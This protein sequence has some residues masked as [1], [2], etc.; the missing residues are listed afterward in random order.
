MK[1]LALVLLLAPLF[2]EFRSA[3]EGGATQNAWSK[4]ADAF[5]AALTG[6]NEEKL[7]KAADPVVKDNSERAAKLLL[8]GLSTKNPRFYWLLIANL[9]RLGSKESIEP[10]TAAILAS[11]GDAALKRDLMMALQ[12]NRS[13]WADDA[14]LHIAAKGT[15]DVAVTAFDE[16][17]ARGKKE[18][19]QVLIDALKKSDEELKRRARKALAALTGAGHATA[20]EWQAWWDANAGTWTAP[21]T[22]PKAD[23]DN[24]GKTVAETLKRNRMTDYEE[25]T[26]L[27]AKD[28]VVVEGT[29]DRV[30]DVLGHMKIPHTK[31]QPKDLARHDL[32]KTMALLINCGVC[33]LPD[34]PMDQFELTLPKAVLEKIRAFVARGGYLFA[35]DWGLTEVLEK[36]FPGTVKKSADI[37]E[38]VVDIYPK[39]GSTGHPFLRE[40]FVKTTTSGGEDGKSATSTQERIDFKWVIDG[41]TFTID[42]DPAKVVCLI[43]APDLA[44]AKN[45]AVAVT[46]TWGDD[47]EAGKAVATGGVFENLS[48]IKSGK[49]LHVL[50]H[51]GNQKTKDDTYSVQ[52]MLL[53]F[54]IEAKDRKKPLKKR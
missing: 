7:Q 42:Y 36:A 29:F 18:A 6:S 35:S 2:D 23:P 40:V 3:Q 43:E 50:S 25:L 48:A 32:S 9:A 1:L 54:L 41:G 37:M 10:V 44:D 45:K 14:I 47:R 11:G 28:I 12:F 49:V 46:F 34:Q 52:N 30:E 4:T 8:S 5:K 22:K 39:K 53:N 38:A 16:L 20:K 33:D 31:I 15:P 21:G 51:F 26:K 19:V 27:D 17:V 13:P 24:P